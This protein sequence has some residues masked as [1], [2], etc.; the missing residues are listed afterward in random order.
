[1]QDHEIKFFFFI[2]IN[3]PLILGLYASTKWGKNEIQAYNC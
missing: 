3:N 1:M 2:G